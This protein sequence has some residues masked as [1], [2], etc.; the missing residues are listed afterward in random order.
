M[1]TIFMTVKGS[2]KRLLS[3]QHF[4][5]EV[6]DKI[7][8]A[9]RIGLGRGINLQPIIFPNEWDWPLKRYMLYDFTGY[10]QTATERILIAD[11]HYK[12]SENQ[13]VIQNDCPRNL[14]DD[15]AGKLKY[16]DEAHAWIDGGSSDFGDEERA[17]RS[18]DGRPDSLFVDYEDLGYE[19][20]SPW[21]E[22]LLD[23]YNATLPLSQQRRPVIM[24][25]YD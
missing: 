21:W 16:D 24:V 10:D 8:K 3:V 15:G 12:A 11:T 13:N 22:K 2:Y 18:E 5:E 23:E 19:L 4:H 1:L 6:F 9:H 7:A 20:Y 25:G 14:V 17:D